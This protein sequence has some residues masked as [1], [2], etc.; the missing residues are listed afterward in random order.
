MAGTASKSGAILTV[1]D[2]LYWAYANVAMAQAAVESQSPKYKPV[3]YMVRSRLYSGLSKGTMKI[4]PLAHDE[5]LKMI[6]PQVCCYC[7]S[8]TFL[9]ADHLLPRKRGGPNTGDN[10]VWACRS[11]NSSKGGTDVLE[12]LAKRQQFPPLLL[13][14]RYLKLAI[15]LSL[16]L[17]VMDVPLGIAAELPF[18]LTAIPFIFPAPDELVLWVPSLPT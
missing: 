16:A 12:W 3:H 1:A 17:G 11:C 10:M 7:G 6:L 13:L 4:G 9:A 8:G 18:V 15:E 14:R 2:R 5:R